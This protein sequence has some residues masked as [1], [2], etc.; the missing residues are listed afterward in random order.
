MN[1]LNYPCSSLVF[2]PTS[3]FKLKI[4][5]SI[6]KPYAPCSTEQFSNVFTR[7]RRRELVISAFMDDLKTCS[8]NVDAI[9]FYFFLPLKS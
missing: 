3:Y 8:T 1:R 5:K 7:C 4:F 9:S 2:W 6:N